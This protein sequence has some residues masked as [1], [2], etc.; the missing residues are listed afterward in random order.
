MKSK[1]LVMLMVMVT[2]SLTLFAQQ[3][4][5]LPSNLGLNSKPP[6]LIITDVSGKICKCV[7]YHH[8]DNKGW[9]GLHVVLIIPNFDLF[10]PVYTDENGY[11]HIGSA[12]QA[13]QIPPEVELWINGKVWKLSNGGTHVVNYCFLWHPI[14]DN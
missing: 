10:G 7:I 14:D 9:E 1:A 8:L 2:L 3:N 5:N 6:N 4:Y 12:M 13:H 11:Y